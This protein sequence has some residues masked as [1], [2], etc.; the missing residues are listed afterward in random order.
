MATEVTRRR[1]HGESIVSETV[2]AWH[3]AEEGPGERGGRTYQ[4]LYADDGRVRI[5]VTDQGGSQVRAFFLTPSQI[6]PRQEWLDHLKET[7]QEEYQP[8]WCT[9]DGREID[10]ES[11]R[12]L[13]DNCCS[14]ECRNDLR[15]DW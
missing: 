10:P 3:Y 8:R 9:I 4:M 2:H 14:A 15:P 6:R 11:D 1:H 7:G 12:E 5:D 13:D